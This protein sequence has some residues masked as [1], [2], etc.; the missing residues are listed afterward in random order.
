VAYWYQTE[1]H[2]SFP[3]LPPLAQRLPTPA[4]QNALQFAL[5]TSPVWVP[6]AVVGLKLLRKVLGRKK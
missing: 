6:A 2:A 3:P 1:P 5:F 4:E